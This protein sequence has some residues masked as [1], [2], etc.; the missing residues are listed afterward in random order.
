VSERGVEVVVARLCIAMRMSVSGPV[1]LIA[2][3]D[4]ASAAAV[5]DAAFGTAFEAVVF[6]TAH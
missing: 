3:L 2:A 5:S 1:Q 6:Q 4:S